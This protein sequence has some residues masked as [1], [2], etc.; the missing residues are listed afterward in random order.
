ML[1]TLLNVRI[2]VSIFESVIEEISDQVKYDKFQAGG[3]KGRGGIGNWFILMA[4]M[5]QAKRL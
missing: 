3:G 2:R 4:T 1:L 5:D